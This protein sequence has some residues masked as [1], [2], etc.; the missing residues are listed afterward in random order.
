MAYDE[1]EILVTELE[2]EMQRYVLLT[3]GWSGHHRYRVMANWMGTLRFREMNDFLEA[4]FAEKAKLHSDEEEQPT[5]LRP[6][7]TNPNRTLEED[8]DGIR[9]NS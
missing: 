4:Q 5:E 6:D 7:P 8:D 3:K 9:D 1:G 2:V